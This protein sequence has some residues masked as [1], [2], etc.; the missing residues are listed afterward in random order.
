MRWTLLFALLLPT[1]WA[2]P[3]PFEPLKIE[4]L[5]QD[6][7]GT[8]WAAG[9]EIGL[10]TWRG[11]R[12]QEQTA[13]FPR[14]ERSPDEHGPL[15]EHGG[16]GGARPLLVQTNYQG[17]VFVLWSGSGGNENREEMCWLTRFKGTNAPV[18]AA[19]RA[20]LLSASLTFDPQGLGWLTGA[21][22]RIYRVGADLK[23]ELAA[24]LG[25]DQMTGERSDLA[26]PVRA[27]V[28]G[29]GR[30]WLWGKEEVYELITLR[31]ILLP[32]EGR[33]EHRQ[34]LED[35][36]KRLL[37]VLVPVSSGSVWAGFRH[38]R[39]E[40][41]PALWEIDIHSFAA[42]PVSQPRGVEFVNVTDI[43]NVGRDRFVLADNVLWRWREGAWRQMARGIDPAAPPFDATIRAARPVVESE[44]GLW[45]GSSGNGLLY[46]PKNDGQPARFLDWH[47]GQPLDGVHRIEPLGDGS[48]LLAGIR[49]GI[50]KATPAELLRTNQAVSPR[51][52]E[53][54]TMNS[55]LQRDPDGRL[56][57]FR[58]LEKQVLSEW[59]GAQWRDHPIPEEARREQ[60]IRPLGLDSMGSVW[61]PF[62]E[63][64]Q[65][66]VAI[67]DPPW[68]SWSILPSMEEALS[69]RVKAH[70]DLQVHLPATH[71]RR[72]VPG[73]FVSWKPPPVPMAGSSTTLMASNGCVGTS[74]PS[75][76][77]LTAAHP[78]ALTSPKRD[79][80]H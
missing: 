45:I 43:F 8:L 49:Q 80:R 2:Q 62:E 9:R 40:A 15:H 12:W 55:E 59:D 66:R 21:G 31:G 65:V 47:C 28:D 63:K 3:L 57:G 4:E 11:N 39:G 51:L 60:R 13:A 5:V 68:T 25:P 17:E 41:T 46:L 54:F 10:L 77:T 52:L 50:A 53:V 35:L 79:G 74:I 7:T 19:F 73:R 56:W 24:T 42:A 34:I 75:A 1:A 67:L 14:S 72:F 32:S 33:F 27:F 44:E 69:T 23:V 78:E 30:L 16:T 38:L 20:W 29:A 76:A 70:P 36:R 26:N 71:G 61:L 37:S 6:G 22:P 64:K 18:S 48:L 58:S